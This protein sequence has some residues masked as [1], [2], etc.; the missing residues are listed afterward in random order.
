[1]GPGGVAQWTCHLPK[2][3]GDPGSK[4]NRFIGFLGKHSSAVAYKMT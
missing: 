1:M 4:P 3:R 2:K